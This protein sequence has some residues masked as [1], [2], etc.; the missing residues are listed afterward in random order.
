MSTLVNKTVLNATTVVA[1]ATSDEWVTKRQQRTAVQL[2]WT[3]TLSGTVT[4][5]ATLDGGTTW[6]TVAAASADLSANSPD[7]SAGD[8]LIGF[9]NVPGGTLRFL[10]T[11]SAGSGNL[12]IVVGNI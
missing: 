4:L 8:G 1:N 3:G 11:F 5:E 7:G 12:K 10:F 2:I 9:S 6:S